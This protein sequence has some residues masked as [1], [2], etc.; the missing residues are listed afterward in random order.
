MTPFLDLAFILA[1][2][3]LAAKLGGYVSSR[4]G[5]PSVLG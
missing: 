1:A 4:M 2:I 5:Q 3:L